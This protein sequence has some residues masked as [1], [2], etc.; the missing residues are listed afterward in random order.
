MK[1]DYLL[2]SSVIGGLST[3][4]GEIITKILVLLNIGKYAVFELNSLIVTTDTPSLL[5]G[6]ICNF[7][8]GSFVGAVYYLVFKKLGTQ[9]L[10]IKCVMGSLII[11]LVFEVVFS[12][13][14]EGI[15]IPMRP[16]SD[17]LV[18]ITGTASFGLALGIFLRLLVF[19]KKEESQ[20]DTEVHKLV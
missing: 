8:V 19:K 17:H 18:H 16:I 14:I 6:F 3:I 2:I 4:A 7:I 5:M 10:V 15:H 11:W 20:V 13:M 9:H 12:F 1:K